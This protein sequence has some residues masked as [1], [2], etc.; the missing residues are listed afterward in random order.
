MKNTK[1]QKNTRTKLNFRKETILS[2]KISTKINIYINQAVFI[3]NVKMNIKNKII[4]NTQKIQISK[5]K[6]YS[7]PK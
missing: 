6:Y 3:I 1:L 4:T 5:K 2:Y 7:R